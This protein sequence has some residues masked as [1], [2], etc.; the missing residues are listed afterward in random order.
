MRQH[1]FG[2]GRRNGGGPDPG[3]CLSFLNLAAQ[4]HLHLLDNAAD[5]RGNSGQL[6][7]IECQFGVALN[8]LGRRPHGRRRGLH[9]NERR[10]I[11]RGQAHLRAL[12]RFQ[13]RGPFGMAN[14]ALV[15]RQAV[16]FAHFLSRRGLG[17]DNF[18]FA[19]AVASLPGG[20]GGFLR[21]GAS[22]RQ[23]QGSD[24]RETNEFAVEQS[25]HKFSG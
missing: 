19:V 14:A 13:L 21:F 9:A 24:Q 18:C 3:H 16:F 2:H 11:R 17:C 23:R 8:P 15:L 22:H 20:A 7:L 6:V 1:G 4:V 10:R 12:A 5:R 25:F